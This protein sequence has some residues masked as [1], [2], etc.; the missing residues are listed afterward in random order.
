MT[1]QHRWDNKHLA[2]GV[3]GTP[4]TTTVTADTPAAPSLMTN[5]LWG[6][7]WVQLGYTARHMAMRWIRWHPSTC[8]PPLQALV[9]RVDWVLMVH[10][11]LHNDNKHPAPTPMPMSHC[12]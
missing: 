8:P 7:L 9:C 10:H 11:H 3:I 2:A 4:L 6:G 12:S 1:L 5:S